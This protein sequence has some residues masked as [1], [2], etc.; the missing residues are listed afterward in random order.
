MS[1]PFFGNLYSEQHSLLTHPTI[2][3]TVVGA[4]WA[5]DDQSAVVAYT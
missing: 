5:S 2:R 3:V 1:S 4:L